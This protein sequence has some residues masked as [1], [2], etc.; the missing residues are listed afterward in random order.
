M[1]S[2]Y[3]SGTT[4]PPTKDVSKAVSAIRMLQTKRN[5]HN[6]LNDQFKQKFGMDSY[7]AQDARGIVTKRMINDAAARTAKGKEGAVTVYGNPTNQN[8]CAAG[9]CTVAADAG[10]SFNNMKGTIGSG[11]ATDSKGRKIPQYNPLI[12]NQ[13]DQAG[14]Y[15]VP[16]G[17]AP[18]DG[19]LVQ[20]F[21]KTEAGA[22]KPI[23][24]EFITGKTKDGNYKTFNNYGLFNYGEG[25]DEFTDNR[26]GGQITDDIRTTSANKIYRLK[27]EAADAAIGKE[28]LEL[29]GKSNSAFN[30]FVKLR[31]T[32]IDGEDRNTIMSIVNG[33]DG[34]M[35]KEEA[36]KSA[37]YFAKDKNHVRAVM[38]ELFKAQGK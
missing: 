17:E 14:Y 32:P 9:V 10:V 20:Y 36:M 15:E 1:L 16:V 5:E 3:F 34:E 29:F 19:D 26:K 6:Q 31:D 23:H 30:E 11:L 28:G 27:P 37:L 38:N 13:I 33:L 8:T 22:L 25:E 21:D 2:Q 24:L 12:M 4:D 35:S 7:E 18:Q